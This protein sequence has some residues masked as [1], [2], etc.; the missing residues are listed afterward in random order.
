M[1]QKNRAPGTETTSGASPFFRAIQ[2]PASNEFFCVF[3]KSSFPP[4]GQVIRDDQV[5]GI[6]CSVTTNPVSVFR[7]TI[8]SHAVVCLWGVIIVRFF[9]SVEP[10]IDLKVNVRRGARVF[11]GSAAA[12][13]CSVHPSTS[14]RQLKGKWNPS[15]YSCAGP[16]I[17]LRPFRVFTQSIGNW[18]Q[19]WKATSRLAF[20]RR[21]IYRTEK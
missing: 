13:H 2:A 20:G 18:N 9:H 11:E 17:W 16:S 7:A 6:S 15:S 12:V 3:L 1:S 19:P 5:D 4:D 8:P 21:K 14:D 10:F